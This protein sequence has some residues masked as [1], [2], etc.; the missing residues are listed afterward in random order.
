MGRIIHNRC[1]GRL[2]APSDKR[3]RFRP[4]DCHL[5]RHDACGMKLAPSIVVS[6]LAVMVGLASAAEEPRL[7]TRVDPAGDVQSMLWSRGSAARIGIGV[8]VA[9]QWDGS[10]DRSLRIGVA[11][12]PS[13]PSRLVWQIGSPEAETPN[14]R[15]RALSFAR[16]S[17]AARWGLR[18]TLRYEI[19]SRTTLTI[20]PRRS[21]VSVTYAH[22]W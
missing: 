15:E 3:K 6:S 13:A 12:T 16:S 1:A 21:R 8:G 18:S 17:S 20:K 11:V 14:A 4:M 19:D 10:A 2:Q 22:Q 9:P 5:R 7:Q